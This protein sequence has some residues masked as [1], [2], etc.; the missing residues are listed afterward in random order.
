MRY[1]RV[2]KAKRAHRVYRNCREMVGT[3]LRAFAHPTRPVQSHYEPNCIHAVIAR[4]EATKQSRL[5]PWKHSGLLRYARNDGVC[6]PTTRISLVSRTRC[7]VQRC[8]AEPGSRRPHGKMRRHGPRL[9]SAPPKGR[10]AASGARDRSLKRN[11]INIG[12]QKTR[13]FRRVF[14]FDLRLSIT[15]AAE[16][17]G[18][19]PDRAAAATCRPGA[20]RRRAA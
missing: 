17:P 10:C 1:R 8:C 14:Q 16:A 6:G 11:C 9:R 20:R 18:R 15:P 2:G 19:D 3:A 5:L 13:R 4:S 12:Q 7:C